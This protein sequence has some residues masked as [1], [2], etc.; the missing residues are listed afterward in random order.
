MSYIIDVYRGAVETNKRIIDFA[1]YISMF[2]QLIAGPI[3]N[4]KDIALQLRNHPTSASTFGDGIE[5]FVIGL[6]R[7]Y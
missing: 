6:S 7:K 3:V 1:L 2:P 4:Y 5:R